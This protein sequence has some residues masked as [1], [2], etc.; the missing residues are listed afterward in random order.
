TGPFAQSARAESGLAISANIAI[1]QEFAYAD[2]IEE[3]FLLDVPFMKVHVIEHPSYDQISSIIDTAIRS[4][5]YD[6][7]ALGPALEIA[8]EQ[9]DM[10]IKNNPWSPYEE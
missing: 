1:A 3:G 7:K 8:A 5:A 10:V 9:V 6:G 4:A 2:P